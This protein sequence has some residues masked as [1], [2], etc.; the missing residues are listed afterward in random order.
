ME[1]IKQ[2]SPDVPKR[3]VQM[4]FEHKHEYSSRW[5]AI[6]SIA[7]KIGYTSVLLTP[8]RKPLSIPANSIV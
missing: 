6:R 5:G 1:Y 4:A 7:P 3:A 2:Y 8:V